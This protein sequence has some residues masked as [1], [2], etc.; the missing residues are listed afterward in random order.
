MFPAVHSMSTPPWARSVRGRTEPT[1]RV[2]FLPV[3]WKNI[4]AKQRFSVLPYNVGESGPEALN[5]PDRYIKP[6]CEELGN[7]SS[8]HRRANRG[9]ERGRL[10]VHDWILHSA[11]SVDEV[12]HRLKRNVVGQARA[13]HNTV[14]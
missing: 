9:L 10:L 2:Q 12:K 11:G 5:K 13:A 1:H 6:I 14:I 3:L 8:E 7:P 4:I